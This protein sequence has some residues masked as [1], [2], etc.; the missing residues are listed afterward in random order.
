MSILL[1]TLFALVVSYIV[2]KVLI[3]VWWKPKNLEKCLRKQGIDGTPYKILFGDVMEF[4]ST[5]EQAQSTPMNLSHSI[6]HRVVPFALRIIKRHGRISYTWNGVVPRVTIMEP[7]LVK[8][9]LSNKS[10]SFTKIENHPLVKLLANGLASHEGEKWA[11]HRRI[12]NPAFHFEK[13]KVMVPAILASCVDFV[14]KLEK[15]GVSS[16]NGTFELDVW[17]EI[18]KL[19]VDIISRTAF[20]SSYEEGL[21]VFQLQTELAKLLHKVLPF[22]FIP[23]FRFFP[24]REVRKMKEIDRELRTLLSDIIRKRESI[25]NNKD[26]EVHKDDLLGLMLDSNQKH[27]QDN[28]N[29]KKIGMSI[30][31]VIEECKLFYIA[32]QGTTASLLVW[33][34]VALSMHPEWQARA[35]EEVLS[36]FGSNNPNFDGLS[37]LKIVLRL[38]PPVVFL[39]RYNSKEIKL[40]NLTLPPGVEIAVPTILAHHDRELWGDDAEEFNPK[41]F[42]NGVSK[43]TNNRVSFFPFGW[44]PRI[45][46][47]QTFAIIEAKMAIAM[48]LQHFSFELSPTYA[49]A[50]YNAQD[51][52]DLQPQY[53]A[54][55]IFHKL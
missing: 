15:L 54:H 39:S 6:T 4:S 14:D 48:I 2:F 18:Q 7:E 51:L 29:S 47:G 32:G 36:L 42:S 13:M 8:E 37:H 34:M 43:A 31:D 30:H 24:T 16:N 10:S 28:N 17:P 46:I 27:I 5:T 26:G 22:L 23:G 33:T 11:K 9:V 3:W 49:H 50:P 20:G 21:K 41:R 19:T 52:E 12:A 35:R 45:C 53:G 25:G 44:G 38:Y 1:A 55:I 40:G